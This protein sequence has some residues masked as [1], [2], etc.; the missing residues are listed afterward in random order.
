[1]KYNII[2]L[3]AVSLIIIIFAASFV[4]AG[5]FD[6]LKKTITGKASTTQQTN[7]S[8][9]VVGTAMITIDVYNETIAGAAATPTEYDNVSISFNITINDTDGV[10]D[11]NLSSVRAEFINNTS[12]AAI[13][14][15]TTNCEDLNQNTSSTINMTCTVDM[16]YWD[17]AGAW[18]INVSANDLG[19]TTYVSNESTVFTYAQLQAIQIAPEALTWPAV[20]PGNE[21]QTSNNDPT[22]VNNTGNYNI[23]SG[24]FKITGI[25]LYGA[26][27]GF[28]DAGNFSVNITSTGECDISPA[29]T[30]RLVNGSAEAIDGAV[31]DFGNLSDGSGVAQTN[32]YY[33]LVQVPETVISETY[34]TSNDGSDAWVISIT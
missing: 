3:I 13:R 12:A 22:I 26:S 5:L 31:L 11:I 34:S 16:W 10:A 28:I 1:M 15:S 24:N 27:G 14:G 23:T 30:T 29:T 18:I 19:N 21:N 32:I 4:S 9:A 2:F 6:W 25:N 33:C 7:V 20:A 8:L 17:L